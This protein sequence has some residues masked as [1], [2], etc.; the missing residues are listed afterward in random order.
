[1]CAHAWR[2]PRELPGGQYTIE[3][4]VKDAP[5]ETVS[6]PTKFTLVAE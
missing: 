5:V 1:M 3:V 2:V 4:T 6:E